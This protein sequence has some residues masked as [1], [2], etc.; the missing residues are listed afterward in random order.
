[1]L[2]LYIYICNE[3]YVRSEKKRK[4][5]R[6]KGERKKGEREREGREGKRK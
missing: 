4:K 2:S 1:M 6:K 3:G 5:E